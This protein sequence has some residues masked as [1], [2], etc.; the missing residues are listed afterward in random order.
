MLSSPLA[1]TA[2][3]FLRECLGVRWRESASGSGSC[4]GAGDVD[5][6]SDGSPPRTV[7]I[8]QNQPE[9]T[10]RHPRATFRSYHI[11]EAKSLSALAQEAKKKKK[12][13]QRR[14]T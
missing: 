14:F 3:E 11:V 6:D 7:E 4:V 1:H 8:L 13:T 12:S 9:N 10:V 2:P 5:Q